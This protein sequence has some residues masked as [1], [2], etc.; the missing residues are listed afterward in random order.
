MQPYSKVFSVSLKKY[1]MSFV[2]NE[3]LE[4]KIWLLDEEKEKEVTELFLGE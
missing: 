1:V 4:S 3:I 2:L